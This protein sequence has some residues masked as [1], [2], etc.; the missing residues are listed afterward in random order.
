MTDFVSKSEP[1]GHPSSHQQGDIF[2]AT[3]II[4]SAIIYI[5]TITTIIITTIAI[6]IIT[7]TT[8]TTATTNS[9]AANI[10]TRCRSCS[11]FVRVLMPNTPAKSLAKIT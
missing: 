1:P 10:S 11:V 5:S 9:T 3:A 7:T 4:I 8:T 2:T 6:T